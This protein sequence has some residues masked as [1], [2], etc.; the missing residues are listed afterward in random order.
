[1]PLIA[2]NMMNPLA[3]AAGVARKSACTKPLQLGTWARRATLATLLAFASLV[4]NL[5]AWSGQ[6]APAQ[7]EGPLNYESQNL[8][9]FQAAS[10][11]GGPIRV[12]LTGAKPSAQ[13]QAALQTIY[14]KLLHHAMFLKNVVWRPDLKV[15]RMTW[16][17]A[18]NA[19]VFKT[20]YRVNHDPVLTNSIYADKNQVIDVKIMYLVGQHYHYLHLTHG[21]PTT[22]MPNGKIVYKKDDHDPQGSA[23]PVVG[24]FGFYA[25][26][27]HVSAEACKFCHMLVRGVNGKPGGIFFPRYQEAKTSLDKNYAGAGSIEQ[28][29]F[30]RQADFHPVDPNHAG[31][32]LPPGLPNPILLDRVSLSDP[33][34]HKLYTMFVRT[35]FE[36]P[37]LVEA[38][39]RDNHESLCISVDFQTASPLFGKDNYV[40]ADGVRRELFV[41]F[42]NPLLST[43]SGK[44]SYSKP[45]YAEQ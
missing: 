23:D 8:A 16:A 18:H 36:A 14:D 2:P 34:T 7:H 44:V 27:A 31:V 12:G 33:A 1:M 37:Q 6:S 21:G 22:V 41:K 15:I 17:S 24:P 13:A 10:G 19:Y 3:F 45:Y 32:R 25:L 35:M 42:R 30:F 9:I 26:N 43:G 40:C 29:L 28:P 38:M 39:A 5:Q 11:H 4:P 20:V